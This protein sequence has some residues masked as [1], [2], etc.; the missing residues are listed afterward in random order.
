MG[1]G[2]EIAIIRD[3]LPYAG[4]PDC[5][6]EKSVVTIETKQFDPSQRRPGDCFIY[7]ARQRL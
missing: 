5:F 7:Q 6:D 3:D 2:N 1:D 4:L